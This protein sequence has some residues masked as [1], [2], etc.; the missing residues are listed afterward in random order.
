MVVQVRRKIWNKINCRCQSTQGAQELK[1]KLLFKPGK[2]EVYG[3]DM[4]LEPLPW[5]LD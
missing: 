4:A 3:G 5:E 2:L 1:S